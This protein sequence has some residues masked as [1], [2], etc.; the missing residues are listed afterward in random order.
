VTYRFT[1]DQLQIRDLIRVEGTN[2]IQRN[3]IDGALLRPAGR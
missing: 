3:I 1:E 2:Q